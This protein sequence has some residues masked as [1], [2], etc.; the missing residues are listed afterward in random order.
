MRYRMRMECVCANGI[1]G[2]YQMLLLWLRHVCTLLLVL[3]ELHHVMNGCL[4]LMY[5]VMLLIKGK[6]GYV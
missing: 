1:Q 5:K 4:T 2:F 3:I 6:C